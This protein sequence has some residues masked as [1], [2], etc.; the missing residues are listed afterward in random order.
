MTR[1]LAI[2]TATEA[3]SAALWVNDTCL[4][5]EEL[6]PQA[7]TRKILPMVQSLLDE[8]GL[9]LS[10]LDAI[11]FGRGPG[12][13]TG[14]RIG[15]GIAQG[16][17]L[18]AGLPLIGIS[19][20]ATLAQGCLR[21]EGPQRVLCA[22]DARMNEVYFG[23]FQRQGELMLPLI[24]EAVLSPQEA[25]ARGQAL[26]E[27]DDGVSWQVIGTGF[28]AY[29]ETLAPLLER[30]SLST[31]ALPWARDMLPLALAAHGRGE[32]TEPAQA[33]PVYLRDK[34]TWKKLPGRE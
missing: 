28:S 29:A 18:G 5:R 34:V 32:Q 19:N 10:Q 21:R 4:Y 17:A 16:L 2:D 15:I 13:F 31:E 9:G 1:I 8:A 6:A 33:S 30:T 14:V 24:E 23:A 12:S 3:C 11:A 22:I 26:L 7:H 25:L 27:A 20:L